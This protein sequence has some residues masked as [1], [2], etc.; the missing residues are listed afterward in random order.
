M[1]S[2][3]LQHPSNSYMPRRSFGSSHHGTIRFGSQLAREARQDLP[4][5][6]NSASVQCPRDQKLSEGKAKKKKKCELAEKKVDLEDEHRRAGINQ[7]I[8]G[9]KRQKAA[10]D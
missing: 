2:A 9:Q 4:R 1:R 10:F 7:R 3:T 8:L 6:Q 5:I